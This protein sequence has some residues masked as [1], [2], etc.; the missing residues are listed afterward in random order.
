MTLDD[1][2]AAFLREM[3]AAAADG[4]SFAE[5][6]IVA[7]R[8]MS[9]ALFTGLVSS[10]VPACQSEDL[11]LMG[12][13]GP[14]GARFY[15]P[16][17]PVATER[18]IPLVVFFH[19][20]GWAMGDLDSYHELAGDLCDRSGVALLSVDYRLAPEHPFPAGLHDCIDSLRWV[21]RHASMLGIDPARLGV[22][23]DS[24][25]GN[26]AAVVAHRLHGGGELALRAQYLI[27]P[28]LDISR[29]HEAYPSRM[30]W[31]GGG[32][33]LDRDAIDTTAD[34]Y[35]P[36]ATINRADPA[37]S[38]L[39]IEDVSVLPPTFLIAAGHDP[40]RSENEIFVARLKHAGVKTH[41]RCFEGAIHAFLSFHQFRAAQ[42]ARNWLGA[43]MAHLID[44]EF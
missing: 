3:N 22:M 44:D 35:V 31:G 11:S 42:A 34:W 43:A 9:H 20:G 26:L 4:P 21:V 24:A 39:F 40:L 10:R 14:I 37:L 16:A 18:A 25:G 1:D 27:Y 17:G 13:D 41:D 38:P 12:R 29:P 15:R 36:D 2:A 5:L 33:L 8:E 19:G 7:A 30:D 23:G 28:M 6:G 32:Y